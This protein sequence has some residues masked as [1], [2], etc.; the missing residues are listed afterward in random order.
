MTI[1][2][3]Q[4]LL[5]T[6]VADPR[7][8]GCRYALRRTDRGLEWFAGRITCYDGDEAVFHGYPT[9]TVPARVLRLF[10]DDK[11]ISDAEYRRFAK[12]RG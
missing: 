4:D 3:R 12:R 6:S 7:K 11:R 2:E 5:E 9:S 8:A 1:A 10:R